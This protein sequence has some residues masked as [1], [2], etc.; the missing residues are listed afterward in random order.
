MLA[1]R[2][3]LSLNNHRRWR[4][5]MNYFSKMMYCCHNLCDFRFIFIYSQPVYVPPFCLEV[6]GSALMKGRN[7]V[8]CCKVTVAKV[9]DKQLHSSFLFRSAVNWV[10]SMY[11]SVQIFKPWHLIWQQGDSCIVIIQKVCFGKRKLS[12]NLMEQNGRNI[13]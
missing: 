11:D 6:D 9:T 12:F 8:S 5:L 1:F 3:R 4:M 13:I 2:N 7:H 10:S